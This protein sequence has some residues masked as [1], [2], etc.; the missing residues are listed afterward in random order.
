[1]A[2]KRSVGRDLSRLEDAVDDVL[3]ADR[4]G[5]WDALEAYFRPDIDRDDEPDPMDYVPG[6]DTAREANEALGHGSWCAFGAKYVAYEKDYGGP[7]HGDIDDA[8]ATE[9]RDAQ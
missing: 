3:E 4:A 7:D 1:M 5:Y 9:G 2:D 8:A 6:A